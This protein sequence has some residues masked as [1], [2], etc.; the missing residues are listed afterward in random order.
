LHAASAGGCRIRGKPFSN[1]EIGGV[2]AFISGIARLNDPW[3][4]LV[5]SFSDLNVTQVKYRLLADAVDA[6]GGS[7]GS[8]PPLA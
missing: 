6:L 1:S 2:I 7:T 3:G 8:H 4:D 5:N